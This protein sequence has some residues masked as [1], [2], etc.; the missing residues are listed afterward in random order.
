MTIDLSS[1]DLPIWRM[2]LLVPAVLLLLCL[3]QCIGQCGSYLLTG[4]AILALTLVI[5]RQGVVVEGRTLADGVV[6]AL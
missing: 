1:I 6:L 3:G 5:G 4:A 2:W